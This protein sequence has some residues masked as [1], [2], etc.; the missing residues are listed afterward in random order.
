MWETRH[1]PRTSPSAPAAP[2]VM[3]DAPPPHPTLAETIERLGAALGCKLTI[4]HPDPPVLLTA[5]AD[6]IRTATP[7]RRAGASDWRPLLWNLSL[8]LSLTP[9][10]QT[11][12]HTEERT[13]DA[14][15]AALRSMEDAVIPW[16]L[17]SLQELK[18]PQAP[19]RLLGPLI[20]NWADGGALDTAWRERVTQ[21]M[22]TETP[23][24]QS[25]WLVQHVAFMST[26]GY[27]MSEAWL[28]RLAQQVS[29]E[30]PVAYRLAHGLCL[31]WLRRDDRPDDERLTLG[32]RRVSSS[33]PGFWYEAATPL[34]EALIAAGR[35]LDADLRRW[36]Y[37][38]WPSLLEA[39][40]A[41]ED[42]ALLQALL[43][44]WLASRVKD[45]RLA[46]LRLTHLMHPG[47]PLVS[48][49]FAAEAAPAP[50]RPRP[51]R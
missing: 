2:T 49:R 47:G 17:R 15:D 12:A 1:T 7:P 6:A 9:G 35:P 46:G 16:L 11:G 4:P 42:T 48:E 44:R 33:L 31:G 30:D 50:R 40:V 14:M 23:R 43:R 27:P 25:P 3:A 19:A 21:E 5:L 32:H 13:R 29:R 38:G 39:R 10:A 45:T 51:P 20:P 36:A 18:T 37:E 24:R 26:M 28:A 8:A 41:Q 34:V 22:A